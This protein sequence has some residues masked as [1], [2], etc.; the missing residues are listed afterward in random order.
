MEEVSVPYT[1][2]ETYFEEELVPQDI[3]V[4][5]K[6]PYYVKK[7]IKGKKKNVLQY[8]IVT[9]KEQVFVKKSVQK[10]RP[11]TKYRKE[12][13]ERL[14]QVIKENKTITPGIKTEPGS[15]AVYSSLSAMS[16]YVSDITST[17]LCDFGFKE[18]CKK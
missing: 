16:A 11:I 6:V 12:N 13:V 5:K 10:E 2:I 18:N 4:K 17:I 7:T 8:K 15:I 14:K 1:E 9:V 3:L